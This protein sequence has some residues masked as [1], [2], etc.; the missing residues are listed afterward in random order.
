MKNEWVFK[1]KCNGVY[2][3]CLVVCCYSQLPGVDFS[4]NYSLVV[5]DITFFILL[6][7]VIH[8]RF[9]TKIVDV[10]TPFQ[11]RDLQEEI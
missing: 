8:F 4:K 10:E 1:I 9:V 2:G 11:Y 7:M 5:D 6:L 3:A